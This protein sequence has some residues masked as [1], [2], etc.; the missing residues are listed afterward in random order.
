VGN[1]HWLLKHGLALAEEY[2]LRFR[3]VHKSSEVICWCYRKFIAGESPVEGTP[4]HQTSFV[5]A[6]PDQYKVDGDA[7]QSYRNYYLG[8]KVRFATWQ[9]GRP[10]PAWFNRR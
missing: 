4:E 7:I 5:L 10:A 8:D 1:Y 9:R 2:I 6:M 3:R